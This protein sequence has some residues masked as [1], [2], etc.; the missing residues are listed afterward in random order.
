MGV[1]E[2][3]AA[4]ST[5]EDDDLFYLSAG[6]LAAI[7]IGMGLVPLRGFTV[8]SNFT[9]VFVVLTIVVAEFGGRRAALATAVVSTLSLDFFLTEPYLRL[10]IEGKHD[11]IA[12][13]GLA[14]CGLLAASL[15]SRRRRPR[16]RTGTGEGNLRPG[17]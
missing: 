17:P 6:P 4:A 8:A 10:E 11:L 1:A 12:F 14:G 3:E 15:A 13:F 2:A 5:S 9:F 7:V 16:S